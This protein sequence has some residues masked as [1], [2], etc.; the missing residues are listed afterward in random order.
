MREERIYEFEVISNEI[1]QT[2]KQRQQRLEDIELSIQGLLEED[3]GRN[4]K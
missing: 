4:S 2:E 1:L 3:R